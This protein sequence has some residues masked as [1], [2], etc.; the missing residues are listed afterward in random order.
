MED[1]N[2]EALQ[3]MNAAGWCKSIKE[4]RTLVRTP[5]SEITIGS[6]T[7]DPRSGNTGA[8]FWHPDDESYALNSLGLPNQGLEEILKML[9][10][11]RAVAHDNGKRLRVSIAAFSPDEYR[12]MTLA[13]APFCDTVEL[14]LGCPNVW[15]TSGQ[16][17]IAA[18]NVSLLE[19]VLTQLLIVDRE[20]DTRL[21]LKLSPYS[22][23]SLLS[24]VG[25]L[26]KEFRVVDEIVTCNTFPNGYA[27]NS[28]GKPA[29]TAGNGL[30]GMSGKALKAIALGQASQFRNILPWNDYSIVGVGGVTSAI[31][32]VD[33]MRVGVW[34]IQVG[35][36]YFVNG[37]R[38]FSDLLEELVRIRDIESE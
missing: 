29:I 9:P 11:M 20:T 16:K 12:A 28:A 15:G 23:P 1:I 18:F 10:D 6:I 4:V 25:S 2:L 26:I 7:T 14:N 30:A 3:L 38:V 27:Y 24:A 33:F 31:D 22:D 35:T 5:I 36:H 13:V 17:P 19:E 8:T 32:I 34:R 37:P 21:A